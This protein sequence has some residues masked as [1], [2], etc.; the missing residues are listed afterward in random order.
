MC[1]NFSVGIGGR[2]EQP[3]VRIIQIL[4]NLNRSR[5]PAPQPAEWTTEG[6]IGPNTI[7]GIRTFETGV[8]HLPASDGVVTPD[9]IT[10]K[11][12]LAGLEPGATKDKLSIILPQATRKN[13]DLYFEPLV[14][15]MTKYGI[16]TP[17]QIAHFIAQVGLESGNFLY[18]K[19]LASGAAYEGAARLGNTQPGDG[20]KFK[21]RGLIQLTGRNNYTA[22]SQYTGID[23]LS[24]PEP[25]ATEPTLS[26]DAACWFWLSRKIGP[27]ADADDV[28]G[29]TRLINGA[30]DGP[31]TH[32]DARIA[33][34]RRAKAVL[35]L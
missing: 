5:F 2:N 21:G 13:I 24:N 6:Q 29:V 33:N 1:I 35:G 34:L 8:M 31:H 4:L 7:Q 30:E 11:A 23:Y 17:L 12:L 19:E 22:Y 27:R 32:L 10:M 28:R 3:D 16:T 18:S 25:I 20:V 26:V 9:D 15:G 14:A